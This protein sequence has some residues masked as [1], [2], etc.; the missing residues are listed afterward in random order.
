LTS[1]LYHNIT[2]E[3]NIGAGKT[4]LATRL[5]EKLD[6]RLILESFEDNPFLELF[7]NDKQR[8]A[9]QVEMFF[10]TER[11]HQLS[12]H[13]LG[14][15]FHTHTI[16]D[17]LFAKSAIFSGVNLDGSEH[18]LFLNLYRIMERFMPR[19]DILIYLHLPVT[20]IKERIK[21]RGRK[22]EQSIGEEYLSNVETAYLSFLKE[23]KRFPVLI[24][25]QKDE[26]ERNVD[27]SCNLVIELLKQEWPKGVTHYSANTEN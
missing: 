11:Y 3:G 19:P 21:Q 18:A 2:I 12:K 23:E 9:F 5:S 13:L 1:S 20:Q 26:T 15:I 7:Y 4:T 25:E 8:Y 6:A 27:K 10:L 24:V 22:Y 17:Y 14:D 16:A